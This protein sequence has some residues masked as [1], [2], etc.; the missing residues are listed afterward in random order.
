MRHPVNIP[1]SIEQY[2]KSSSDLCELIKIKEEL[3]NFRN[4]IVERTISTCVDSKE[5]LK[6]INE[7]I[8]EVESEAFRLSEDMNYYRI[9]K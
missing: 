3:I 6:E 1:V 8:L 2:S 4:E 5:Y 7:D 9:R